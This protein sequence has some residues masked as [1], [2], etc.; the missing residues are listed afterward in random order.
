LEKIEKCGRK[1]Q[2][3][4]LIAMLTKPAD[5]AMKMSKMNVGLPKSMVRTQ[6]AT[7]VTRSA[8]S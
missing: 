6:V 4:N 1:K 2:I 8:I 3:E 7:V 5:N